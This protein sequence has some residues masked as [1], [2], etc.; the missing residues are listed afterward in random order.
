M[1]YG[2]FLIHEKTDMLGET[3]NGA[4]IIKMDKLGMCALVQ[5][6]QSRIQ[7]NSFFFIYIFTLL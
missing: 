2:H 7:R 3:R 5:N 4:I 6:Y 1:V